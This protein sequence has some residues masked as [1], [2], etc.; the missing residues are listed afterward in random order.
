MWIPRSTLGSGDVKYH[1]GA[2]GDF[3][4]ANGQAIGIHLV[5]N[6]SH[7]EAADP[8]V[9]GRTRAKQTR[10][11]ENG[12]QQVIAIT[13]HGDAAFAGQ[14]ICAETLNMSGVPDSPWA[15]P[16]SIIVNNLIGFTTDSA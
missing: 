13:M 2:T 5:S 15:A 4:A 6:P 7:L 14:G 11:G 16:C 9:I 8:V 10:R 1:I 3:H 12:R